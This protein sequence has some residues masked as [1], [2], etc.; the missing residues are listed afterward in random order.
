MFP[1][2]NGIP[3]QSAEDTSIV[4][5]NGSGDSVAIPCPKGTYITIDTPGLHYNRMFGPIYICVSEGIL[6]L[7]FSDTHKYRLVW[8]VDIEPCTARYW[9]DP[10]SFKPERFLGDWPRDAFVP[11]SA[12]T[13]TSG[14]LFPW[15]FAHR[16]SGCIG[17]R[18]C[19]GRRSASSQSH[20]AGRPQS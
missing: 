8:L 6:V 10:Y 2:V 14:L 9:S 18:A 19:I 11:F 20:Y 15:L 12:G 4:V 7:T 1:P 16:A 17:P 5:G 13:S 3:K